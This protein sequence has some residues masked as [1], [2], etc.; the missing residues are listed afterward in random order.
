[1]IED[2]C[3]E[4]MGDKI[5]DGLVRKVAHILSEKVNH[6]WV[7]SRVELGEPGRRHCN[8]PCKISRVEVT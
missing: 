7:L 4:M 6:W 5:Q 2:E 1:M 8:N 3:G